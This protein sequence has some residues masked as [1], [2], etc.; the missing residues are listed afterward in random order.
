MITLMVCGL[1]LASTPAW[2]TGSYTESDSWS[3]TG[4]GEGTTCGSCTPPA[5]PVAF[6]SPLDGAEVAP[7]VTVTVEVLQSCSCDDCGCFE[8][9][10][11]SF[12]LTV[13]DAEVFACFDGCTGS[14]S[15]APLDLAPGTHQLTASAEYSFHTES[16]S[17]TVTVPGA[18]GT[19]GGATGGSGT[20]EG[21]AT[22]GND[23]GGKGG[24]RV[25]ASAGP[26]SA[27]AL[28]L[29]LLGLGR[30]R[31]PLVRVR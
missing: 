19:N 14:L 16:A 7:D 23:D 20:G 30:R 13:D 5:A 24:C 10:A 17:I 8:D 15:S 31:R 1:C 18:G 2:G 9:H 28:G 25:G 21:G 26:S 27:L 22:A 6:V 4:G 11:S 12:V 29:V 3:T